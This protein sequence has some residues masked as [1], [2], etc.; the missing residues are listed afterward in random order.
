LGRAARHPTRRFINR[1]TAVA[2]GL[3]VPPLLVAQAAEIIE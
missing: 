1:K 2:L 3:V